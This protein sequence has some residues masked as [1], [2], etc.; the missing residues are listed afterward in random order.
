MTHPNNS[1]P[2]EKVMKLVEAH[3]M[4]SM[5]QVFESVLNESMKTERAK[6]LGA[7]IY[8]RNEARRGVCQ[9]WPSFNLGDQPI[10]F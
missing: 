6:A 8:Q 10:L 4:E 5:N 7:A 1:S 2:Y 9:P 3:G